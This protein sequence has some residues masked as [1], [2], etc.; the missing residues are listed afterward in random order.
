MRNVAGDLVHAGR[1]AIAGRDDGDFVDIGERRRQCSH[2][3]RQPG[4]QF[5]DDRG[6]VV[7]LEGLG[8]DVHGLGFGFAFFQ[9]DFGFRFAL[10]ADGEGMTLRFCREPHFFG[11]CQSLDASALHFGHFQRG[12]N[13]F[14]LAALD[15]RLRHFDLLFLLHLLDLHLFKDHLLLHDIGLDVVG[16]VGLRLLL[17][18]GFE[19][20]RSLHFQIAGGFGL[21]GLRQ[22]FRE[23]AFLVRLGSGDSGCARSF[24]ALDGGIAFGLGSGDI[25]IAL[26]ARDIRTSHIGDIFVLVPDF[27]DGER[28]HFQAHLA[29]IASAGSAHAI[30]HHLRLLDNLFHRKLADYSTQM[31]LHHQAN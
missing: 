24:G 23:H 14:V 7:F 10:R 25:R 12:S 2:Y 30:A 26:D 28:N 29:H 17:L 19:I 3:F 1:I 6:L 5:V 16:L 31:A 11:G 9:D 13:Q 22:C 18:G 8:F 20:Q 27:L 15:F 21:F 4:E